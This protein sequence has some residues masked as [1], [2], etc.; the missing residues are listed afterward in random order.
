MHLVARARQRV[1]IPAAGLE[2]EF[3]HAE[4]IW[5]ES[6]QKY[7][8]AD[9]DALLEGGGFRVTARWTDEAEGFTLTLGEAS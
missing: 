3:A 5:T 6:S 1:R 4:T 2:I 7:A 8:L 9:I